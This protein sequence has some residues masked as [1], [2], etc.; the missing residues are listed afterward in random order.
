[1]SPTTAVPTTQRIQI[2]EAKFVTKF[3]L[4][5]PLKFHS[6][7]YFSRMIYYSNLPVSPDVIDVLVCQELI[8]DR[9]W[10]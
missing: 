4:F 1:M 9:W 5:L 7:D 3:S 2:M 8:G 6:Y 10:V